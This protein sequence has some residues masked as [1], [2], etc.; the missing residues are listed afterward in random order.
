MTGWAP[1]V[2]IWTMP[3]FQQFQEQPDLLRG[4]ILAEYDALRTLPEVMQGV[5]RRSATVLA[6]GACWNWRAAVPM[7]GQ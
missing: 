5:F 2:Q 3:L 6:A 1:Q 4:R 7:C